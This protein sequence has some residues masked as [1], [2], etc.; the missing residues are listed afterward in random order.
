M[1]NPRVIRAKNVDKLA[2]LTSDKQR[3]ADK[4]RRMNDEIER[5]QRIINE[6]DERIA[7]EPK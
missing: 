1:Q 6:M 4:Q 7:A 5:T 2:R 3:L